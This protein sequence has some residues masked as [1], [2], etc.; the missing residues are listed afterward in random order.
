MA[1]E[2]IDAA[3][4]GMAAAVVDRVERRRPTA[5]AA[6]A[7]P[8]PSLVVGHRD[9]DCDATPPGRVTRM[10]AI[11]TSNCGA[12]HAARAVMTS[13]NGFRPC[14]HAERC[15]ASVLMAKRATDIHCSANTPNNISLVRI[16]PGM[17]ADEGLLF[18][19]PVL[20]RGLD[21]VGDLEA[22]KV[23]RSRSARTSGEGFRAG[24]GSP[25]R[26]LVAGAGTFRRLMTD[27]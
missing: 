12:P 20:G 8:M 26:L 27:R 11:T 25:G 5:A 4:D 13:D 16:D 15:S 22:L 10:P 23:G 19:A 3:L 2:A 21:S 18:F 17:A 6:P 1:L 24:R 9:G 7:C 14:S